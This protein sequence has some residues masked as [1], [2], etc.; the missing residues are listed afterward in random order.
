[1]KNLG[2]KELIILLIAILVFLSSI[3]FFVTK[4]I[5]NNSKPSVYYRT[6]T[7]EDG[8]SKWAKNGEVCGN[9]HYI[10]ALQIKVKTHEYGFVK[11]NV[12]TNDWLK[13]DK[14]TNEVAGNK[15]DI[16]K[17]TRIKITDNLA[18]KY[19]IFYRVTA[20]TKEWNDYA[21]GYLRA[22]YKITKNGPEPIKYIQIKIDER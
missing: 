12:L 17:G 21:D 20:N 13:T 6:Y 16:V 3:G 10:T 7:K 5:I 9:D 15:K 18:K 8:W 14:S 4:T 2:K 11:Y 22:F 19:K 1:M